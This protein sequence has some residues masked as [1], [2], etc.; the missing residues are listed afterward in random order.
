MIHNMTGKTFTVLQP[1]LLILAAPIIAY[2]ALGVSPQT[3][4]MIPKVCIFLA[5]LCFFWKMLIVA[6]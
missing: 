3:E 4:R 5:A 2:Y 6:K 1:S